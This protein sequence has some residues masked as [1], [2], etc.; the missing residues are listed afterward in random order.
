[1]PQLETRKGALAQLDHWHNSDLASLKSRHFLQCH[2]LEASVAAAA[3]DLANPGHR[4]EAPARLRVR[5]PEEDA[6]GTPSDSD[7]V[8]T[9]ARDPN[10]VLGSAL[11]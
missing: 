10:P 2:Y 7:L 11:W 5:L 4:S 6:T 9:A 3:G 8:A 1:M